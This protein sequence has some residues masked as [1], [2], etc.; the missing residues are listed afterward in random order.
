MINFKYYL[1][2]GPEGCSIIYNGIGLSEEDKAR[3]VVVSQL[4]IKPQ[5]QEGFSAILFCDF[6]TKEV[7]WEL[8]PNNEV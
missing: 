8:V 3:A 4:P 2:E 6:D 1:F 5:S 7:W